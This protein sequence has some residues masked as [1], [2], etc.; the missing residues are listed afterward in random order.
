MAASVISSTADSSK[1]S[2][3][4]SA[5]GAGCPTLLASMLMSTSARRGGAV[6]SSGSEAGVRGSH[7]SIE[8]VSSSGERS[9][10]AEPI[11]ALSVPAAWSFTLGW[12]ARGRGR[13]RGSRVGLGWRGLSG[14]APVTSK[15]EMANGL[16]SSVVMAASVAVSETVLVS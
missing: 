3:V 14:S 16:T 2:S 12:G 8:A 10:D 5:E 9:S 4:R 7:C 6:G 13:A 1:S 11:A 15:R